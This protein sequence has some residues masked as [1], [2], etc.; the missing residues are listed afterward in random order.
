M[1][2]II[3]GFDK[4]LQFNHEF[5]DRHY[6]DPTS[7]DA[8][9]TTIR[10]TLHQLKKNIDNLPNTPCAA[11]ELRS[12]KKVRHSCIVSA[13]APSSVDGNGKST[14]PLLIKLYYYYTTY[15]CYVPWI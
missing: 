14:A 10:Q 2:F 8:C 6:D 9:I 5:V 13:S 3:P 1:V 15:Q 4:I 7:L 11:S 12:D